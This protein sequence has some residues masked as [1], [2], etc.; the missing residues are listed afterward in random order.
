MTCRVLVSTTFKGRCSTTRDLHVAAERDLDISQSALRVHIAQCADAVDDERVI[1]NGL[2][3]SLH[4]APLEKFH[5]SNSTPHWQTTPTSH[6]KEQRR[7]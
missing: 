7:L 2:L 3:E 1:G 5:I 4:T 6:A